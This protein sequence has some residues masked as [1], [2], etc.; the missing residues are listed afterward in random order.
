MAAGD[1]PRAVTAA[2]RAWDDPL[3]GLYM[4]ASKS[5]VPLALS[6]RFDEALAY[7]SAMWDGWLR[8]GRPTARWM[9][10]AVHGA[11][12]VHG[13]RGGDEGARLHREWRDRS[14]AMAEPWDPRGIAAG[15]AAF[16]EARIALHPGAADPALTVDLTATPP[17]GE[18]THQFYD[19]YSWAVAAETAVAAGLP[20]AHE[21]LAAASAAGAENAWAAACLARAAGRLHGDRDAL[22]ESLAGWERIDAAF[23]RACTLALLPDRAAEGHAELAALGCRPPADL[24]RTAR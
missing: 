22:R 16:A 5:V 10:P 17:W 24:E 2:R 15:F 4:R 14:R 9:A 11:A 18:A 1:L 6:G 20:D 19:A 7:A 13:L 23:E 8:A 3:S 12:L 21:H